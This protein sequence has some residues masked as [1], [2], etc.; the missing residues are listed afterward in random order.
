MRVI[1][2][3]SCAPT[4]TTTPAGIKVE[5][6]CAVYTISGVP[7][8]SKVPTLT[9]TYSVNVWRENS[10]V[11]AAELTDWNF[12]LDGELALEGKQLLDL[13]GESHTSAAAIAKRRAIDAYTADH[14]GQ[15]TEKVYTKA[16]VERI[17]QD[18]VIEAQ[19]NAYSLH[20]H[21]LAVALK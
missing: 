16:Q 7:V 20:L 15:P 11:V 19:N 2:S 12:Q 1:A 4:S 21:Y 8:T 6:D 18:Y 5:Q 9:A 3:T 10:G 14:K 13:L 17:L